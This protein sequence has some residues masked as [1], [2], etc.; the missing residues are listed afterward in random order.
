M[1]APSAVEMIMEEFG[2]VNQLDS[3]GIHLHVE[4]VGGG[5]FAINVLEVI[6]E[7]TN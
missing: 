4:D 7:P 6:N 2:F 1:P 3:T 5:K